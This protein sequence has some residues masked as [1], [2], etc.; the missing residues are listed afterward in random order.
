[1]CVVGKEIRTIPGF[2]GATGLNSI[3]GVDAVIDQIPVGAKGKQALKD[4]IGGAKQLALKEMMGGASSL[5]SHDKANNMAMFKS[6][7]GDS[8]TSITSVGSHL[9]HFTARS[10]PKISTSPIYELGFAVNLTF[11]S[12]DRAISSQDA[13]TII[14]RTRVAFHRTTDML[15]DGAL[16]KAQVYDDDN[17]GRKR[18]NIYQK[19]G[20][21]SIGHGGENSVWAI[22]DKG[23]VRAL[24]DKERSQLLKDLQ[25]KQA[26]YH[27]AWV[28][29]Q[30]VQ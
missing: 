15:P 3:K 22:K 12:K 16:L 25:D 29:A 2:L 30:S 20:F 5:V 24:N 6:Q 18:K 9:L 21:E 14:R 13:K 7:D 23:V 19:E 26:G 10:Q 17:Q 1:M 27:A 28:A 4:L 8:A 11:D